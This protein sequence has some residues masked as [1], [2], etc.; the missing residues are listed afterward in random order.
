MLFQQI[1][2]CPPAVVREA[3][4]VNNEKNED[5]SHAHDYLRPTDGPPVKH[6]DY[7]VSVRSPQD[8]R[9]LGKLVGEF[10]DE[11]LRVTRAGKY[12]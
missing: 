2:N 8:S 5:A 9:E 7:N 10:L 4:K 11:D 6:I 3:Q 12:V 1:L